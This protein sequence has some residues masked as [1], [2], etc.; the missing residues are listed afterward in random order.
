MTEERGAIMV[1]KDYKIKLPVFEDFL[2]EW[3]IEYTNTQ[4]KDFENYVVNDS[5]DGTTLIAD[6]N[7][8]PESYA[9]AI[10]GDYADLATSPRMIIPDTGSIISAF[11][12]S[13]VKNEPGTANTNRVFAP[14]LYG[15]KTSNEYAKN[16]AT[17]EYVD[18]ADDDGQ[19]VV[20][21][22]GSRQKIDGETG[23]YAH[24]YIFAAASSDF[25]SSD[26]LGN[27]SYANY[28]IVSAMMKDIARL[29]TPADSSLGGTSANNGESFLGKYLVD[30][31]LK[32]ETENVYEWDAVQKR[33][34]V[35]D[36]IYGLSN[37]AKI[38][39]A[40]VAAAIPLVVAITGIVVCIKR[41]YL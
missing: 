20:A 13:T 14:F 36:V 9:Y 16:S 32:S 26:Y 7:S 6:Y 29:D 18:P 17:G 19:R 4:V 12:D 39:Y 1:A 25:F 24:S 2:A 22:I 10:Y 3:G 41:K 35:V 30:L 5:E 23:N 21:A 38:V 34:V 28:D 33:Y 8:D 31:T 37:T 27:A 11:G 40:C 15:S